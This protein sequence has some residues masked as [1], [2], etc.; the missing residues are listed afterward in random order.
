MKP[1]LYYIHKTAVLL[2]RAPLRR[3]RPNVSLSAQEVAD[4]PGRDLLSRTHQ[5]LPVSSPGRGLAYKIPNPS[6]RPPHNLVARLPHARA[7]T[8]TDVNNNSTCVLSS[9]SNRRWLGGSS[10][11]PAPSNTRD[12]GVASGLHGRSPTC[13]AKR[14]NRRWLQRTERRPAA[15]PNRPAA[16]VRG[17][18][19]T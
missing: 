9:R 1:L 4:L 8:V 14:P 18:A 19:R 16:G 7:V 11:G 10:A 2:K 5:A 13:G 6:R 12:V 17:G 3:R 15:R